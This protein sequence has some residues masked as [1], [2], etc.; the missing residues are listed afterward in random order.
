MEPRQASLEGD[1]PLRRRAVTG[2]VLAAVALGALAAGGVWFLLLVAAVAAGAS[3][4]LARLLE[5][6]RT[7]RHRLALLLAAATVAATVSVHRFGLLGGVA[8]LI[9]MAAL[10]AV[11]RAALGERPWP[12]ALAAVYLG[13]PLSLLL[14]LRQWNPEGDWLTLWLL[15]V[16]AAT[17]IGGYTV[18]RTLRGPRLAPRLSPGKTWSGL[19]GAVVF[20]SATGGGIALWLHGPSLP[21]VAGATGLAAVLALVAQAG[22]LVES[23][24]KRRAGFKDSGRLL[25]GHGGLLDRFD[26]LLFATP[27]YA[28]FVALMSAGRAS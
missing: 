2:V 6:R 7:P 21:A 26:G 4:E 11:V 17:D 18:G 9:G 22:D 25:P 23:W 20:A 1:H 5:I 19:L 16:V 14:W 13:L 27:V 8:V 28:L 12:A 3:F 10:A 15:A 24:L